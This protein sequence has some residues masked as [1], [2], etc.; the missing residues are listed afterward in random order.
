MNKVLI[1]FNRVLIGLPVNDLIFRQ[2]RWPSERAGLGGKGATTGDGY[3]VRGFGL[4]VLA[5]GYSRRKV[6]AVTKTIPNETK[7]VR[8]VSSG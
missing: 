5:F 6:A 3:A 4:V 1:C 2:C 7:S 8:E